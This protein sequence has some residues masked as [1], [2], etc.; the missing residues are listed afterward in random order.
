MQVRGSNEKLF[1][2]KD[3]QGQIFPTRL[4]ET[5]QIPIYPYTSTRFFSMKCLVKY[6]AFWK[7]NFGLQGQI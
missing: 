5:F 7:K 3:L 4:N 6:G 1:S 2:E